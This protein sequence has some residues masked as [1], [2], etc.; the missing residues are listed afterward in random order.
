MLKVGFAS[1]E[2]TPPLGTPCALGLD[3]EAEAILG[4]VYVRATVLGEG[5]TAVGLLSAD[6]P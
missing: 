5:A 1:A 3:N 2:I 4:P 6:T